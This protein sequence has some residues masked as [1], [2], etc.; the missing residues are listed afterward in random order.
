MAGKSM[1]PS[2]E[3]CVLAGGL[4]S[5]MGSDKAGVR[6]GGKTMLWHIQRAVE[7]LALPFR[8][9]RRDTV[10]RCGP[11]GGVLTALRKTR[12]QAVLFLSC[13][14]PFITA[15]ILERIL[16]KGASGGA[17]VFSPTGEQTGFPFLM[18]ASFGAVVERRIQEGRYSLWGL[19]GALPGKIVRFGT[20]YRAELLNINTLEDLEVAR[21]YWA[22]KLE[23]TRKCAGTGEMAEFL[24]AE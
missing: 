9:I 10:P 15:R 23:R 16:E 7:P 22:R 5:R 2:C 14:M 11:L 8:V 21:R 17:G 3:I 6:I 12:V 19:A 1:S 24:T 4:S 20:R 18:R 13:D